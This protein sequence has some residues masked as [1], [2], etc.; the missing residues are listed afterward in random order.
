MTKQHENQKEVNRKET[1]NLFT[2]NKRTEVKNILIS[3]NPYWKVK[4]GINERSWL[5]V[6]DPGA[7]IVKLAHGKSGTFGGPSSILLAM[8]SEMNG[9]VYFMAIYLLKRTKESKLQNLE[10]IFRTKSIPNFIETPYRTNYWKI[11]CKPYIQTA[12]L[13]ISSCQRIKTKKIAA[14]KE[15]TVDLHKRPTIFIIHKM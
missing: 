6:A 5:S 7:V 1:I 8:I 4:H 12:S 9:Q 10:N 11:C 13:P 3:S 15:E 2:L 14:W